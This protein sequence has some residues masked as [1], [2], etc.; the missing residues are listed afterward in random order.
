MAATVV[1]GIQTK[2]YFLDDR[3]SRNIAQV[4]EISQVRE[5]NPNYVARRVSA[6]VQWTGRVQ[7]R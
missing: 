4:R 1:S 3:N 2:I 7:E 5:I 6:A